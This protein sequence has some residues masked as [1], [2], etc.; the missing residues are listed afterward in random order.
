MSLLDGILRESGISR[1]REDGTLREDGL[2]IDK[3]D[4]HDIDGQ[5]LTEYKIFRYKNPKKIVYVNS[6]HQIHRLGGPALKNGWPAVDR[7]FK[8]DKLH[9]ESGPAI[10]APW[11]VEYWVNGEKIDLIRFAIKYKNPTLEDLYKLLEKPE[12][13][14]PHNKKAICDALIE[15]GIEKQQAHKIIR[16]ILASNILEGL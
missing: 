12:A 11:G 6:E 10:I 13:D 5:I 2:N 14:L 8:N 15:R 16:A 4:F 7:W 1:I 3:K 9:C